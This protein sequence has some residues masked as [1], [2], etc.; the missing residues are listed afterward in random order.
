MP[1]F[2]LLPPENHKLINLESAA[3]NFRT[4]DDSLQQLGRGGKLS[5]TSNRSS[6]RIFPLAFLQQFP[7]KIPNISCKLYTTYHSRH[8]LTLLVKV[9]IIPVCGGESWWWIPGLLS[10]TLTC[11]YTTAQHGFPR[12]STQ[13]NSSTTKQKPEQKQSENCKHKLRATLV[14]WDRKTL[15]TVYGYKSKY[16]NTVGSIL[17]DGCF[18]CLFFTCFEHAYGVQVWLLTCCCTLHFNLISPYP[19]QKSKSR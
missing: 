15:W 10:K 14:S 3:K 5:F 2:C 11:S 7:A 9:N 4:A 18:V 6:H 19:W 12:H 13:T 1:N 8:V 17:S 16:W